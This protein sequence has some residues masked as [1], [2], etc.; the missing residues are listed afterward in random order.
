MGETAAHTPQPASPACL[1]SFRSREA[2]LGEV[3]PHERS[4]AMPA[5]TLGGAPQGHGWG[6]YSVS[7]LGGAS[8]LGVASLMNLEVHRKLPEPLT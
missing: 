5:S 3:S 6:W 7:M 4:S 8:W 2:S 1:Q